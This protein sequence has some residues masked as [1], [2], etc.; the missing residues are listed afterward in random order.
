MRVSGTWCPVSESGWCRKYRW[1]F[2]IEIEKHGG[3]WQMD[4][5]C[6]GKQM[7]K[8]SHQ[9]NREKK[10]ATESKS[11]ERTCQHS[12]W[13]SPTGMDDGCF[14][15]IEPCCTQMTSACPVVVGS[16]GPASVCV[17]VSVS[18]WSFPPRQCRNSTLMEWPS[19][20]WGACVSPV[21]TRHATAIVAHHLADSR[22]LLHYSCH[23]H[24]RCRC[25][26]RKVSYLY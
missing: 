13:Q 6:K 3:R 14:Q 22:T 26:V 12:Q 25:H 18:V 24:C 17:C 20:A 10:K 15:E 16:S 7:T 5:R 19:Q 1:E 11:R 2:Y 21:I 4:G 23:C 9:T 8:G